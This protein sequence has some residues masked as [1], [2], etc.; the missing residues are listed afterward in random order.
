MQEMPVS[1]AF[2]TYLNAG[3]L[4]AT[5]I[6]F[7]AVIVILWRHFIAERNKMLE[8]FGKERKELQTQLRDTEQKR[9][10]DLRGAHNARMADS[11]AIREKM[12]E[13]V[14]QCTTVMES[15]ASALHVHKDVATEHREAQRE[16][17]EELRKLGGLMVS[18]SEEFRMRFRNSKG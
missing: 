16:A 15:T 17:A 2:T 3:V 12:F 13:V 1:G 10:D 18:L 14:K 6:V 7:A 4:G 8:D 5:V 9:L 11:D